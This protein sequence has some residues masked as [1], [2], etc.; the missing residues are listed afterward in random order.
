MASDTPL[1][2]KLMLDIEGQHLSGEDEVLLTHPAVGGLILFS[3]NYTSPEQVMEL[4]AAVR[5]INPAIL[6]AVDQEGGRVQ[7]FRDQFTPLPAL[8]LLGDH[9]RQDPHAAIALSRDCGWLMAAEILRLGLDLSFA[10]VLDLYSAASE[11]IAERA[12]AADVETVVNLARAY[13]DGMHEA[14][15]VATG[16]HYPG[17]GNVV[18]DSHLELPRDE[19]PLAEILGK[20]Y[21]VFARCA[22]VLDAV[23]PA[24]VV[25]PAAAPECAGFSRYWLQ[26]K[27][28][29][30][31]TFDGVIFSDDLSM[32]AAHS[33]G[34]I[35]DRLAAALAAGCDMVLVCNDRPAALQA[36][37]WLQ[38]NDSCKNN[39]LH[40]LR[41]NPGKEIANLFN[42][43]R[44]QMAQETITALQD[45]K[46]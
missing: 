32:A 1:I 25:Y 27:L 45:R 23:M 12:F 20:D 18:A 34:G 2:G 14:G 21:Q 8:S 16:K 5:A 11:I 43:S 37:D 33:V 3:R 10:P 39:R 46:E 38:A 24:H 26:E 22:N 28:R 9:Y 42:E 30:E 31:L 36:C 15:M 13:I 35:A 44:W 41:A 17:H 6:I 4:V 19:R 7:R 29:Q 40:K